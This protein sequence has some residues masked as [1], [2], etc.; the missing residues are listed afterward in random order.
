MKFFLFFFILSS[1]FAHELTSRTQY[2]WLK[3][4]NVKSWRQDFA[5]STTLKNGHALLFQGTHF[6]RFHEQDQQALLGWR[7]RNSR[8][9][10][11]LSHTQ[12]DHNK[13]LAI[14]ET[15]FTHARALTAGFSGWLTMK[16][17]G[18]H[19]SDVVLSTLGLEKEWQGGWF[20]VPSL[21]LGRA[22]YRTPADTRDVWGTQLRVGKYRED[23]WKIWTYVALA[24][25]AQ[26]LA[27]INQARP[28][29]AKTYG[30]GGELFVAAGTRLGLQLERAYCPAI[31]T[32]FE[33]VMAHL[34]WNW[35][36]H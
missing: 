36:E 10:W 15:Q 4:P 11:E 34:I 24:E 29:K 35:G 27:V 17:L 28:L 8:G 25:E 31:Q 13:I 2:W 12:G 20:L 33:S 32:R 5:G 6:E 26:A 1:A 14:R 9:S 19:T 18:F 3:G 23:H 30:A 22:T 21:S 7:L 16:A